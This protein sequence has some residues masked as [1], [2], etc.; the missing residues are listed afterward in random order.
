[1]QAGQLVDKRDLERVDEVAG[2]VRLFRYELAI[3]SCIVAVIA[4]CPGIVGVVAGFENI[5]VWVR[6]IALLRGMLMVGGWGDL[7]VGMATVCSP[8]R[9]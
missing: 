6:R 9:K 2:D 7:C 3:N 1:M 5:I 4:S 8:S